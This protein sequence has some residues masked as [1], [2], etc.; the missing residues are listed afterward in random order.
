M[1]FPYLTVQLS[2]PRVKGERYYYNIVKMHTGIVLLLLTLAQL[3]SAF[4]C[5]VVDLNEYKTMFHV[6]NWLA[7]LKF[8]KPARQSFQL[9]QEERLAME[10][11]SSPFAAKISYKAQVIADLKAMTLIKRLAPI[12]SR[13]MSATI[14]LPEMVLNANLTRFQAF[15]KQIVLPI[16]VSQINLSGYISNPV[17]E[18]QVH[19][20]FLRCPKSPWRDW[21]Y[22]KARTLLRVPGIVDVQSIEIEHVKID[23]KDVAVALDLSHAKYNGGL[24]RDSSDFKMVQNMLLKMK[25]DAMAEIEREGSSS[26]IKAKEELG[27]M[28][29][30]HLQARADAYLKEKPSTLCSRS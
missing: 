7:K 19:V 12:D 1:P 15:A 11:S 18:V 8:Y 20:E 10:N 3:T 23:F 29:L 26:L 14:G 28:L 2:R 4:Q 16:H 5:D 22:C 24:L 30:P 6:F 27:T 9:E 25:A 17:V 21:L 13:R